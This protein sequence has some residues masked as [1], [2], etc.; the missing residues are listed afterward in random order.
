MRCE[1]FG[2]E[3]ASPIVVGSGPMSYGVP[4]MV[5]LAE[6]GAG[7]VVTKTINLHAADNPDRHMVQASAGTLINC[8]KWSDYPMERWLDRELRDAVEAGVQVIASVGHTVADSSACVERIAE[9]GVLAIELVSY[10][11]ATV[12]PMLEDTRRKVDVPI[13]VKLSPNSSDL[14]GHARRCVDAGADA[15]TACDSM[16]PALLVD[17]ETGAPVLGAADGRGWLSGAQILPFTLEKICSLRQMLAASSIDIPIIG[18]GG[19]ASWRDAIQMVMAGA[20]YVGVCLAAILKGPGFVGKLDADIDAWLAS[21][22]HACLGD[23]RGCVLDHL[24]QLPEPYHMV[25][26]ESTCTHCGRCVRLCPY[27]AR[28]FGADGHDRVDEARCRR[29]GL[30][31]SACRSLTLA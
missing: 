19:V 14:L 30:C 20:D 1:M 13:I 3:L 16:G 28:S 24:P 29:C 23:V 11:D 22:G 31:V 7:A 8:E 25:W 5:A 18:L 17:I 12:L 21:H 9:T 6:A 26:D 15:L 2:K 27:G 10:D 4:G